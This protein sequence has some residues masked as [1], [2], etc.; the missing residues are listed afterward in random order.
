MKLRTEKETAIIEKI[1]GKDKAIFYVNLLTPKEQAKLVD[2]ILSTRG[3][4]NQETD[5]ESL[6]KLKIARLDKTIFDWEGVEDMDGNPIECTRQNKE[7]IY[8]YN[9]D[10]IDEV[11][12]E[13]DRL[14]DVRNARKEDERKNLEAGQNG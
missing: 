1:D 6:Y 9:R 12:D 2:Q 3:K 10:L 5:S 13:A 8:N 7:I 11:L 4:R 14:S